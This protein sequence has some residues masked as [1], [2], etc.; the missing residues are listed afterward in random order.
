M[1]LTT[2]SCQAPTESQSKRLSI[3]AKTRNMADSQEYGNPN[4][5]G[6]EITV[7]EPTDDVKIELSWE[8]KQP[9]VERM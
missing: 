2:E 8:G 6:L 9:F 4:T 7:E 5:S 1:R 3:L